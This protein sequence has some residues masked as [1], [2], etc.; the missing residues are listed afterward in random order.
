MGKK[1]L[2]LCGQR[3]GRLIATNQMK[4]QPNLVLYRL[5]HCD[6]GKSPWVKTS[7]LINGQTQSCGCLQYENR[8]LENGVAALNQILRDYKNA[9]K[10]RELTW[11]LTNAQFR[12]LISGP[13]FF[14]HRPPRIMSRARR[15]NG[16]I[17]CNGIDRLDNRFGY[18]LKNV[19]TCCTDCNRAKSDM[20]LEDFN[21]WIGN[22]SKVYRARQ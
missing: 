10:R 16:S 17:L 9:A 2:D 3:F 21:D 20:S 22:L 4:R 7:R 14:C 1:P 8:C 13:C 19:V 6:C 11:Q 15:C 5:C 18:T 12:S